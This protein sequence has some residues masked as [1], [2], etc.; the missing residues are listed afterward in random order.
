MFA[1]LRQLR[2]ADIRVARPDWL[3]SFAT[4]RLLD[5]IHHN[6]KFQP[7]YIDRFGR[8]TFMLIGS[9]GCTAWYVLASRPV[10]TQ[11]YML[12]W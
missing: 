1:D 6:W 3:R 12:T 2:C 11:Y 8:R 7:L 4:Q 5:D 9:T 10:L